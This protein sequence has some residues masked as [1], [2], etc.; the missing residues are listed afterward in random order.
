MLAQ[1]SAGAQTAESVHD[2]DIPSLP[3]VQALIE[4]S[5][6]SDLTFVY[7]SA[8]LADHSSTP[9]TGRWDRTDA[10]ARLLDGTGLTGEITPNGVLQLVEQAAGD[11]PASMSA[12]RVR[13]WIEARSGPALV[14]SPQ[15]ADVT[16]PVSRFGV[17]AEQ[18]DIIYVT[19]RKR[20]ERVQDVPFSINV[21]TARMIAL[22]GAQDVEDL[23]GSIAGLTI[24]NLGP[25]QSQVAIRGIS[26]GQIVRDQP[27]VKE[28][29][30]VYL[31]ESVVSLS[32]FTPDFDLFDLERVETLRGPQG[33]LFGSG[34][35]AGTIRYITRHAELEQ[36]EFLLETDLHGIE[37]GGVGGS[38]RGAAN[39]PLSDNAAIRIVGYQSRYGGY[40]DALRPDGTVLENVNSGHRTG[41]RL[42]ARLEPAPGL[43]ITPR[44]VLQSIRMDGFNREDD[45]HFLANPYTTTRPAISLADH[46]QYLQID[47]AFEDDIRLADLVI[48]W[49]IGDVALTAISS[50]TDR[51]V[52][53]SRDASAL[54]G[55]VS[56]DLG[57]GD[58][59]AALVSNLRDRTSVRMFTQEIRLA[60]TASGSFDWVAGGFFSNLDRV[61]GQTLPT[62]GW[63]QAARAVGIDPVGALDVGPSD[64]PFYSYIPYEL[65]QIALFGEAS[66]QASERL[67]VTGGLR[68][69]DYDETRR[70]TFDG[71]FAAAT[72]GLPGQTASSGLSPRLLL[73]Y[74]L[75]DGWALN[76]QISK[77]FRLGGINDP[78]NVPLC[79]PED[80]QLFGGRSTFDD[81][82][83]WN[84]EAGFKGEL[85]GGRTRLSGAV[86]YAEI[87]D[88]QASIDAGTCSSRLIYN[89]DRAHSAGAEIEVESQIGEAFELSFAASYADSQLDSSIESE[90]GGVVRAIGGIRDGNR[91]PTVPRLQIAAT[92]SWTETLG[93]GREI[94]LAATAQ[95]VGSR[96]TQFGDLDPQ[97]GTWTLR[98]FGGIA[99]GTQF[100]ARTIS[101]DYLNLNARLGLRGADWEAFVY[102]ENLLDQR[103]LLSLDRERGGFARLGWRTNQPRTLG[104]TL[105]KSF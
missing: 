72:N 14:R 3:L 45:F 6:Q 87:Q 62:P 98:R 22:T 7:P 48:E 69:F 88:L 104:L 89:V 13:N 42:S 91:L 82:T 57:M 27:G 97:F 59:G 20:E 25:G 23:A 93:D 54:T 77:G 11:A 99:P 33:T 90:M 17:E 64:S 71:F 76:G 31:D 28:Q 2:Y 95:H 86:F 18:P 5:D 46:Q 80:L 103:A 67:V 53:V 12:D 68:L 61:Y 43:S 41:L 73:S 51:D 85:H 101:P 78:L 30:G 32:L 79:S 8:R 15:A 70:L 102:V 58:A 4:F 94:V 96:V 50:Y 56:Y 21:Q 10:L 37:G 47:E 75:S 49:Q 44:L 105:R 84:Y 16:E 36:T 26:A 81:E 100:S 24:Q 66:W 92:A 19:A 38:M 52:L 40:I 83:V 60:S 63:D 65:Q 35:M 1:A 39:L 74:D 9:L 55:S 34:S 29:V